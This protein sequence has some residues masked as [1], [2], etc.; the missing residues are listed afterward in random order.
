MTVSSRSRNSRHRLVPVLP[1][2]MN[3]VSRDSYRLQVDDFSDDY[4]LQLGLWYSAR[5]SLAIPSTSPPF[6]LPTAS[7]ASPYGWDALVVS[8]DQDP[9][10]IPL[11]I[12]Q[13]WIVIF[14]ASCLDRVHNVYVRAS[15]DK[16]ARPYLAGTL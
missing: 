15:N 4:N 6:R 14:K 12:T 11:S 2:I 5:V 13:C 16:R 3:L 9:L 1:R 8:L 10:H 7:E